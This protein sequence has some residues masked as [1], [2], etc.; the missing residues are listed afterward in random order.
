MTT[1]KMQSPSLSIANPD[2]G[3]V[4]QICGYL[5]AHPP[6]S[7]FLFAGAGSGKT[8]TLIGVLR[9]LTGLEAD[10]QAGRN[11]A[12]RLRLRGQKICVI[13][14]TN[15]AV[16][17]VVE[18]LGE[19]PLVAVST[20]H[21]F[22]WDLIRGFDSDIRLHMVEG[23]ERSIQEAKSAGESRKKG[24]T[25]KDKEKIE[26]LKDRLCRISEIARFVYS[27]DRVTY[28]PGALQ[29]HDVLS[30]ASS[31][32]TRKPMLAQIL[33]DRYPVILI[34][35]SQDTMKEVIE[36]LWRT[37]EM[38]GGVSLGLLGDHRQ[39]IY[40]GGHSNLA[41]AIPESWER[42]SLQM[43]HRSSK[44]IV[45]LIN[46]IW[47]A[48][49]P[50][51][52]QLSS[53]GEQQARPEKGEGWVR[54]F[55]GCASTSIE[56]KIKKEKS[57]AERM[58]EITGDGSWRQH[59]DGYVCLA[60]EHKLAARRAGFVKLAEAIESVDR[61]G[62]WEKGGLS[63]G[64][65]AGPSPLRIFM[66]P[67]SALHRAIHENGSLDGLA[68]MEVLQ[69]HDR[70]QGLSDISQES[71]QARL[72]TLSMSV[73]VL[74]QALRPGC[75]P[76]LR[77]LLKIVVEHEIFDVHEKLRR[78]IEN[79]E[80]ESQDELERTGNGW[81]NVLSCNWSE[82]VLYRD[83][84][85]D[86]LGYRTQQGVKGSEFPRV[87]VILDDEDARGFS[88]S[89]DKLFGAKELSGTDRDN[90]AE[91]KETTIDRTLRLLYVTCSRPKESLSLVY[92]SADPRTALE[93]LR[94]G[95]WF[96]ENEIVR[97]EDL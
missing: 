70:L 66:D 50:G 11:F 9:R 90:Q 93:T 24:P 45:R 39:R 81:S 82:F 6:R 64:R 43:N 44:R 21:G 55:I 46:R 76:T 23:I 54:I 69:Q 84:L 16:D 83:Y 62:L 10:Y 52:T 4:E 15:N 37:A 14:Y 40:T 8:R 85:A 72:R 18:R 78:A 1:L 42:P 51:R 56:D 41:V 63:D 29:H 49:L 26:K 19:N 88:F 77:E 60:L 5:T 36:A 71:Q 79:E 3:V 95:D 12:Q 53:G 22:A 17:V 91:G 30:I 27:P 31:L 87:Q 7:F 47:A 33:R 58:A 86:R 94:K 48:E 92:W 34:D 67:I 73:R 59:R 35:E 38:P 74:A 25:Q 68:A 96:D 65:D 80:T 13:T 89:Y 57:C 75:D 2:E 20:I 32:L 97:V 61:D 28:G